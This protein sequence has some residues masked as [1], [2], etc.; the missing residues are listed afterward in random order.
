MLEDVHENGQTEYL[1]RVPIVLVGAVKVLL[2][3]FVR[4]CSCE[5]YHKLIIEY[6]SLNNMQK[7]PLHPTR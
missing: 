4:L 5:A 6:V 2:I 1:F 7:I 3:F